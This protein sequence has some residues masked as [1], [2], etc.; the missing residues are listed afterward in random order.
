MQD[1]P[2][3]ARLEELLEETLLP[4]ECD[5]VSAH[6][7]ACP[8]CQ[9]ALERLT[10]SPASLRPALFSTGPTNSELSARLAARLERRPPTPAGETAPA[11]RSELAVDPDDQPGKFVLPSAT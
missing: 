5:E 3:E 9:S 1:C 7:A 10:R 11:E 6:V 4:P 2:A 8:S